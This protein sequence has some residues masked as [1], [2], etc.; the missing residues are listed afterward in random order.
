MIGV[1]SRG[2][3]RASQFQPQQLQDSARGTPTFESPQL[4]GAPVDS[5]WRRQGEA[6]AVLQS[7]V[8]EAPGTRLGLRCHRHTKLCTG[9][10]GA[11]DG[12][13]HFAVE[14]YRT[15]QWPILKILELPGPFSGGAAA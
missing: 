1:I 9:L 2:H 5:V 3:W 14:S 7:R 11:M 13:C 12:R 10:L 8:G 4:Q 6:K 15:P